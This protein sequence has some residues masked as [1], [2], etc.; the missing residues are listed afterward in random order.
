MDAA[1]KRKEF[2]FQAL[3]INPGT[4]WFTEQGKIVRHEMAAGI[5]LQMAPNGSGAETLT[6]GAARGGVGIL[7]L[8]P[9][10]L[11]GIHII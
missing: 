1:G 7:D 3:R 11:Q 9:A 4:P 2:V 6:A 10:I 8:E 5:S